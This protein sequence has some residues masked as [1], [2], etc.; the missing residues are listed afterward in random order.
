M[1]RILICEPDAAVRMRLR[2]AVERYAAA[3]QIHS[4]EVLLSKSPELLL[5]QAQGMRVGLIDLVVCR[6]GSED[7]VNALLQ[8]A[9]RT[10]PLGQRPRQ[11]LFVPYPLPRTATGK[12]KRW[13]L[14]QKVGKL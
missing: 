13:E 14:Q 11:I 8:E 5:R 7:A 2:A 4:M 3:C 9:L 6:V 12:I 10:V 1:R